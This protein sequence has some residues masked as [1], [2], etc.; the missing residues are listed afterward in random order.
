MEVRE[1]HTED[2]INATYPVLKQLYDMPQEKYITYMKEMM[3]G[4]YRL[5]GVF[6]NGKCIGLA[7]F[8]IKRR[9]YC[10]RSLQIHNLAIDVEYRRKKVGHEI[11]EWIKEEADRKKCDTILADTYTENKIAQEFLKNQGFYARGYHLK[12]DII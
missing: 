3:E 1:C 12:C 9:L 8:E 10:G 7:G 6:E 4:G 11:L 2:E 5:V